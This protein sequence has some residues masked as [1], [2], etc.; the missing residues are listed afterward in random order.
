MDL[1]IVRFS[2][3]LALTAACASSEKDLPRDSFPSLPLV[4]SGAWTHGFAD[5]P[6]TENEFYELSGGLRSLPPPLSSE[7]QA[8]FLS[9][10]NQSD[11]LFMF[12][13]GALVGLDPSQAYAARLRVE[14]ATNAASGCV[15]IGGAPGEAVHVKAGMSAA[16]PL[17][18]NQDGYFQLNWDKGNQAQGGVDAAV[19]GDLANST[20]D[21]EQADYQLK[22]F[23]SPSAQLLRPGADGTLWVLVGTDSGFEGPTSVYVSRV[24]V[25]LESPGL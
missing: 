18:T 21:C 23:E 9:G 4:D 15:G 7:K 5:Y 17:S 3:F 24:E 12:I 20:N 22:A 19:L 6:A 1:R 16:E 14:L 25:S 13:K 2:L 8:Y 10:N 11:D